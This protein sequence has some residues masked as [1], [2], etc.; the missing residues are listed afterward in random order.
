MKTLYLLSL[1]TLLF[2]LGCQK[3]KED[4]D[5]LKNTYTD[6]LE[7]GSFD[8]GFK[9]LFGVDL[10]RKDVPF[11]DWSGKLYP[12]EEISQGKSLPISIWYPAEGCNRELNF[13]HFVNLITRQTENS[14][15]SSSDSLAKELFIYQTN[16]L[17][18]EGNFTSD[19]LDTLLNLKTRSFLECKAIEEKFPLV[20]FPNGTSPTGQIIMCEYLA[21]HGYIVAGL[22]LKGQYSHVIDA[23]T[24]GLEV[25]IDDLEF[26]LQ[27]LVGMNNVDGTN[28]ALLANAIES[29]ICAGLVSRNE[30]IDALISLDGGLISQFEQNLL[31]KTVFYEPQSITIPILSIYAPHPSIAP[32]Y[33]QDLK[34]SHRYFAHFPQMSEFHF[35][36]YG[37]LEKF[38]D[39]II[40]STRG[41]TI[42]GFKAAS[43]LVLAFLNATLKNM[44]EDLDA[45]YSKNSSSYI[46]ETIDTLFKMPG[47]AATPN[48]AILKD[49]FI[50]N[51]MSAIDS[52]YEA[53][54]V[55][56]N[57]QPFSMSFYKEFRDW[58]AWKK[59]P[60]YVYRKELYEMAV[61]S[62]PESTIINYYLAY[63]LNKSG[64]FIE[65][66]KH[67]NKT[68]KL[69]ES[70]ENL[71]PVQNE[72]I[73]I[74]I[75]EDL[76]TM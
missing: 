27:L 68:L 13:N 70:E 4:R 30:I 1:L 75:E 29:S 45:M 46:T 19:K 59:D 37:I 65:A 51:G 23:S 33:I 74:W 43:E 50:N 17:G 62:Y 49:L 26:A 58:L 42:Q 9:T 38:V 64:E 31:Q 14:G 21:S 48:I 12:S 7:Y 52:V 67:Y 35:L 28:I 69:L 3:P 47:I 10:S 56:N 8:V 25:A 40:G 44:S 55:Q 16:E 72:Q 54:K 20:I 32:H 2:L 71:N 61:S 60:N 5:E 11:A 34:H 15:S 41:N 76:E 53:H 22:P 57:L 39:E 73:R 36:S 63:F 66:K 24:K 6:I 18:G